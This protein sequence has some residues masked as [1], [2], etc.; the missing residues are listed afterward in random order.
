MTSPHEREERDFFDDL[1]DGA[2]PQ[3]Q[4]EPLPHNGVGDDTSE[5][6]QAASDPRDAA[7]IVALVSSSAGGGCD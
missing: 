2:P 4:A 6:P 5:E 1:S 3:T 7:G